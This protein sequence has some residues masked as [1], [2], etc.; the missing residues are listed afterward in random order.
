MVFS[1]ERRLFPL[2]TLEACVTTPK[3]SPIFRSCLQLNAWESLD[4]AKHP[5]PDTIRFPCTQ[6]TNS[7]TAALR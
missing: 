2:L 7:F 5:C 3:F 4:T 1:P 6:L